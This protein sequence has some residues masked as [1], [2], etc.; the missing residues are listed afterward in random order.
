[1]CFA[2]YP[3]CMLLLYWL[4]CSARYAV[5]MGCLGATE[6]FL[7]LLNLGNCHGQFVILMGVLL[8]LFDELFNTLFIAL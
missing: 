2:V 4:L 6:T 3:T 1:M 7:F 8:G 5:N